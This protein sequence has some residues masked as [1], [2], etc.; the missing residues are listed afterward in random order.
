M[1]LYL[2]ILVL[3]VSVPLL[4]SFDRKVRF[5]THFTSLFPAI[6]IQAI[7]FIL[8][9][10]WFTK[11]GIWGF[12][13]AYVSPV[14]ISGLPLEEWLFFIIIPFASI[15]IHF[16]IREWF[17]RAILNDRIT[18]I[19]SIIFIVFTIFAIIMNTG[20]TYTA[21]Y[22]FTTAL[23]LIFSLFS[24]N[25]LMNRLYISFP[26]IL[27]PFFIVN[28]ILTGSFIESEVVWYNPE[29]ISGIRLLTIPAEDILYGFSM[30][31]LTLIIMYRLNKKRYR[32]EIL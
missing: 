10:I 13:P 17:P 23:I 16:V 29:E 15:F 2:L 1:P 14:T 3:S 12:N 18:R 22:S 5:Y 19:I 24:D 9:D 4:L 31:A 25:R 21:V 28:G 26:V 27:I 6:I 11:N 30:I 8:M 32:E 20:K 7:V